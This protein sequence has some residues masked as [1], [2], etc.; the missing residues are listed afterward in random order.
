MAHTT[1]NTRT[2]KVEFEHKGCPMYTDNAFVKVDLLKEHRVITKPRCSEK[3]QQTTCV[4]DK[5]TS[6]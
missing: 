5:H 2:N 4:P 3:T 1:N 6:M